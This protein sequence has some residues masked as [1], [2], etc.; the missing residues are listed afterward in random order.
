MA[1]VWRIDYRGARTEIASP[2]ERLLCKFRR[3]VLRG[4]ARGGEKKVI[5]E[6]IFS[7]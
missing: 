3:E 5:S 1:I 4:R 6:N 2:L 7:I